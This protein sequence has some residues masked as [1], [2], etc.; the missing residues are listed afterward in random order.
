MV[1]SAFV[2]LEALPLTANRKIDRRAL[3]APE[4]DAVVRGE[5]VAPRTPTEELLAGIWCELLQLD[6]VGVNDNFFEL[7]GHSLLAMRVVAFVREALAVEL[8][9]RTLFEAP[10]AGELARRIEMAQREGLGLLAPAL[11]VRV[12]P[13]HLPLSYAQE[14][15]W[16]L[17]QIGGLGSTYNMPASVR[18]RGALDVVAL[19]RAFAAVVERH[20]ALRTRF[21]VVDGGPVQVI[22]PAGSFEL[23]IED[24]SELAEDERATMTRGRVQALT[25]HPFDLERGPLFR[26]H[27]LRLSEQEHIA[28]VAMHHIVSD[29]WSI[30]VLIREVGALY[31][32]F[33]QGRP[34]RCL[35]LRFSTRIMR[36]GSAAGSRA[37]R[38]RSRL[39]TGAVT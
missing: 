14:R 12:R 3:P 11:A 6:R 32:A 33:S 37:R 19:E 30:G 17:E 10:T 16:L 28:V 27:L 23:A 1:P 29:G 34:R 36:C 25:Q 18:L 2:V 5:Y 24:L 20:E 7:G 21:A 9:L 35:R 38:W 31:A 22:E 26:A 8:P 39:R 4:A 13:E 15:L